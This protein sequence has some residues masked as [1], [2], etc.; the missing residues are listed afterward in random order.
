LDR[1]SWIWG[2][3]ACGLAFIVLT[4]PIWGGQNW[5]GEWTIIGWA[6]RMRSP[7]WTTVMQAATFWG[8]SA[9]GMGLCAGTSAVLYVHRRRL[10]RGVL[11]PV[12][13]MFG[14]API[15]F[16]LR[17]TC[18]RLRPGVSYIPHYMPE[19]AH[20]FQRWSYPS[21]HAMTSL[22][23]YGVLAWVLGSAFPRARRIVAVLLALW[24]GAIGF[25]RVYLGVHWPTDVLGGYLAGGFW[26]CVCIAAP[27]SWR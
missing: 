2:A 15:N 18:G 19:L 20:P 9:V 22:I 3:V 14:S 4:I 27:G 21:G 17:A 12:V 11:L 25:S 26:L 13:A 5:P 6:L 16:G 10:T 7:A 8:S 24:V 23:C 1:K